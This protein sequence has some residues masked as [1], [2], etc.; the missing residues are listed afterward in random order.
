[1]LEGL[2]GRGKSWYDVLASQDYFEWGEV[3]M[4]GSIRWVRVTLVNLALIAPLGVFLPAALAGDDQPKLAKPSEPPKDHK[5]ETASSK[6]GQMA[7]SRAEVLETFTHFGDDTAQPF[8]PLRP[9]TVDDRRR[10]EVVRLFSAARAL[11]DRRHWTDAVALLQEAPQARSR[12]GRHRPAPEPDLYRGAG[13]S[14]PGPSIRQAG[15]GRRAGRHRDTDP[16]GRLI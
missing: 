14:R 2:A 10:I 5:G 13:P 7:D 3:T 1:M 15:A 12:L 9:S 6:P 16:S 4:A 8:V 11:E